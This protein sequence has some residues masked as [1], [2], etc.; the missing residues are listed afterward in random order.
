MKLSETISSFTESPSF[1]SEFHFL[2]DVCSVCCICWTLNYEEVY[3]AWLSRCTQREWHTQFVLG[4]NTLCSGIF[5]GSETSSYVNDM[6]WNW[7][8]IQ[9][10]SVVI[11]V[12]SEAFG[13]A[14]LEED[15]VMLIFCFIA[16]LERNPL[17]GR[18]LDRQTPSLLIQGSNT[19]KSS[20][21][22]AASYHSMSINTIH[23]DIKNRFTQFNS[24]IETFWSAFEHPP[25]F[26]CN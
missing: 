8:L 7:L 21:E 3:R 15:V 18:P 10:S 4:L 12:A 17:G 26:A 24:E 25:E 23:K 19:E 13:S 9:L 11:A 22:T 5:P 20:F 16:L 2:L 14:K 1:L 6:S